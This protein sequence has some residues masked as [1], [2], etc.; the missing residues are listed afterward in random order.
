MAD[1]GAEPLTGWRLGGLKP[2]KSRALSWKI[3]YC[4][5]RARPRSRAFLLPSAEALPRVE[6]GSEGAVGAGADLENQ[7]D[8]KAGVVIQ[9]VSCRRVRGQIRR[10]AGH[11][12][13]LAT[14]TA[15]NG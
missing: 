7:Q 15:T 12:R 10:E 2:P 13:R 14:T 3:L 4:V 8:A 9:W 1:K 5:G 11:R 6:A